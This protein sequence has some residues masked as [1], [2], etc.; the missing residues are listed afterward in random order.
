[1]EISNRNKFDWQERKALT[2]FTKVDTHRENTWDEYLTVSILILETGVV[3]CKSQSM[4]P[5]WQG[6]IF[7]F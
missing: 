7:H 2:F 4:L 6:D 5:E 1:M 3:L